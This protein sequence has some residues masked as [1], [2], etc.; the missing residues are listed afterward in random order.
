MQ[1]VVT[2]VRCSCHIGFKNIKLYYL[3]FPCSKFWPLSGRSLSCNNLISWCVSFIAYILGV[4]A[5]F[6]RDSLRL[7][8]NLWMAFSNYNWLDNDLF[9]CK[10]LYFQEIHSQLVICQFMYAIVPLNVKAISLNCSTR[11]L[12]QPQKHKR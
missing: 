7:Y 3:L 6:L 8:L 4:W 12:N 10:I 5:L 9:Q 11:L 2:S 1:K